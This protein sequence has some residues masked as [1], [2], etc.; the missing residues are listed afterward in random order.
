VASYHECFLTGWL[1]F[2]HVR[3]VVGE[4]K[5]DILK[6]T[7]KSAEFSVRPFGNC[8]KYSIYL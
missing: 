8:S 3:S 1:P 6:H 2:A 5:S 4:N 7:R